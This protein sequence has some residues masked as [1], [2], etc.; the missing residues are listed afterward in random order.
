M[1][2][3]GTFETYLAQTGMTGL[4]R[5]PNISITLYTSPVARM[6]RGMTR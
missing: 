4:V 2:D 1:T 6:N 3:L 5:L